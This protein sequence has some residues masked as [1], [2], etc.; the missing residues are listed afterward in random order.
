M[1][2]HQII[3]YFPSLKDLWSF[4]QE[5]PVK[6]L[7]IIASTCMLFCDCTD[8]DV[9]IAIEKYGA[10]VESGQALAN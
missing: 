5:V 1:S 8:S 3:L 10:K 6:S 2:K 9:A 4:I 7:E